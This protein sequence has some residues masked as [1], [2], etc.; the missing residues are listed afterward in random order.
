MV[1]GARR[2]ANLLRRTPAYS[3]VV[4]VAIARLNAVASAFGQ[5]RTYAHDP[6]SSRSAVLSTPSGRRAAQKSHRFKREPTSYQVAGSPHPRTRVAELL[7]GP[8]HANDTLACRGI[9]WRN[10]AP[11][12]QIGF[13]IFP[14][15]R[16][17]FHGGAADVVPAAGRARVSRP[18]AL[19]AVAS[20]SVLKLAPTTTF[21]DCPTP[22]LSAFRADSALIRR[23]RMKR[24]W[25][26]YTGS[27]RLRN[28][29]S[30]SARSV[31]R[32][33]WWPSMNEEGPTANRRVPPT[34][35]FQQV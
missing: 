3:G 10:G 6:E 1:H 17:R 31:H 21:A 22:A 11:R 5:L 13:L 35:N 33:R 15:V 24:R 9:R 29:S 25:I 18:Q 19:Q 8:W 26:S 32:R 14:N 30:L 23:W 12:V 7:G 20:D 28:M 27:A 2:F 4:A 16:T 34:T